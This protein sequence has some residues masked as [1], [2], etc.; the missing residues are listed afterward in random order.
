MILKS[1]LKAGFPALWLETPENNRALEMIQCP[2][3]NYYSWNC[4]DGLSEIGTA[5]PIDE[6]LRDPVEAIRWLDNFQD[7]VLA[8]QNMHLFLGIPEV[9]TAIQKWCYQMESYWFLL[10]HNRSNIELGGLN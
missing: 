10:G 5:K 2:G 6:T 3:W 4:V 7:T 9:I 8:V 1:Y